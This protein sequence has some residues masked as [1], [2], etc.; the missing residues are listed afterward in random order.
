MESD[1][2]QLLQIKF[3]ENHYKQFQKKGFDED[4]SESIFSHIK[5]TVDLLIKQI[6]K[7][8]TPESIHVFLRKRFLKIGWDKFLF[9]MEYVRPNHPDNKLHDEVNKSYY[10]QMAKA[11]GL[12][13]FQAYL[14]KPSKIVNSLKQFQKE[15]I[16]KLNEL[17]EFHGEEKVRLIKKAF[18]DCFKRLSEFKEA[19]PDKTTIITQ[20]E[21]L[22]VEIYNLDIHDTED[23]E[24]I[25]DVI[26]D[27]FLNYGY[28]D[29]GGIL[30]NY[31]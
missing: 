18:Q 29:S 4:W 6:E 12:D 21:I 26:E 19:P 16:L 2:Q 7:N 15:S 1:R 10:N 14:T 11:I 23:R 17:T 31:I 5:E 3:G 25:A 30:D 24:I 8:E 22:L 13:D 20:F 9:H 27:C 28:T